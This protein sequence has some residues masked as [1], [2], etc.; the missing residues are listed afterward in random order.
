MPVK[1]MVT[2]PKMEPEMAPVK[3]LDLGCHMFHCNCYD[4]GKKIMW[5]L[6]GIFLAY[7][8]VWMGTLIRNNLQEYYFIGQADKMQKTIMV[9]AQGKVTVKPDVAMTTMGMTSEAVT[10]AE[11]QKK[12]TEVMNNLIAKLKALAISED[13]IQ[14]ANYNVYPQ[15][16]YTDEGSVLKG[17]QVYQN[18]NVKIRNLDLANQVLALAGE[19]GANNV[20]GLQ[21]TIDD[22]EVYKAEAREDALKQIAEKAKSLSQM[23][24]VNMVGIVSYNEYEDGGD[25]YPVMYKESAMGL[26]GAIAPDIQAGTNDVTLNVS[27]VFEIR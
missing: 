18:V 25:Y 15:Y 21:F 6:V 10:V 16:D 4:F 24:G 11:A 23:L 17:Y 19:V 2:P 20:S 13:D 9:E 1:K 5:T 27:V 12:N 26:G 22:D 3:K 7:S 8:V 14:T